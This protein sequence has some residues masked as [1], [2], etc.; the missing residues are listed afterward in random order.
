[1]FVLSIIAL[2]VGAGIMQLTGVGERG[3]ITRV[4]SD[5]STLRTALELYQMDAGTYPSTEQGLKAL[6]ERPTAGHAPKSYRPYLRKPIRDPWGSPYGY[7]WPS[8]TGGERPEIYSL[9]KDGTDNTGD[10]LHMD[11]M[12]ED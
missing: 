12:D 4:K 10:E 2:L 7:A 9:G 3:K 11:E 8:R 5:F 6:V 1:V